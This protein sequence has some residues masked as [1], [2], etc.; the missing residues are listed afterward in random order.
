MNV[1]VKSALRNVTLEPKSLWVKN[2]RKLEPLW[3]NRPA[4]SLLL[5]PTP[6]TI[7]SERLIAEPAYSALLMV[8][9]MLGDQEAA[10]LQHS[11]KSQPPR[12]TAAQ[13]PYRMCDSCLAATTIRKTWHLLP[14]GTIN[15][16]TPQ[17]CLLLPSLKCRHRT[18]QLP[19]LQHPSSL[20]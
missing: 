19:Q 16:P 17:P 7:L 2:A 6:T 10:Q 4:T 12:A 11:R 18:G 14:I 5:D 20:T 3:N 9:I 15:P 8:S 13:P 1:R